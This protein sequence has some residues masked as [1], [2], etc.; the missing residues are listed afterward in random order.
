MTATTSRAVGYL[1]VSTEGQGADGF[2]I[3]AQT[4]AV[5]ACCTRLGVPLHQTFTDVI[6]GSATLEQ[7]PALADA[8]SNL[9]SGDVLVV[10]K[11]DRLAR[12]SFTSLVIERE[13]KRRGASIVSCAGEGN[14]D[15]PAATFTRRILAAVAEL[16]RSLIA[17]RTRAALQAAKAR[18]R[19]VGHLPWG[20]K[21]A[22]DGVHLE[23]NQNEVATLERI[24]WLRARGYTM[25]GIAEVLTSE[26]KVN[27]AGQPFKVGHLA[28]LL[29]RH[30]EQ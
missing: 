21:L 6:T 8:L 14:G 9:R 18:G 3:Q 28:Q 11:L 13:V 30:G 17:A 16:E 26:G 2:G 5:A 10:A 24:R 27:R 15:D 29:E 1:R 23:E 12:D 22:D 19:R 4:D 7:R 25:H 20:W